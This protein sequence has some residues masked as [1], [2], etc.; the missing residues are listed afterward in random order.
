[1]LSFSGGAGYGDST[2]RDVAVIKRD[3]LLGYISAETARRDYGLSEVD[4]AEVA[5]AVKV[6]NTLWCARQCQQA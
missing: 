1:M 6:G 3:L 4:I 5:D 2:Q